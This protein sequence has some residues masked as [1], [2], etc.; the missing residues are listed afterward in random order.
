[1]FIKFGQ[2]TVF[3]HTNREEQIPTDRN[4]VSTIDECM[5]RQTHGITK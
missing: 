5:S 4:R 1:M 3:I 2:K